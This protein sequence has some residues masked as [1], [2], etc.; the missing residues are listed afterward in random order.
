MIVDKN[1]LVP[2]SFALESMASFVAEIKSDRDVK[3]I[4]S[5]SKEEGL[6]LLALGDGTNIAPKPFLENIV[7]IFNTKGIE[8]VGAKL[9]I[10]AGVNW[11]EAVD[12]SVKVGL[13]GIE[14]LSGIPGKCGGAPIQNIGAYGREVS[15]A[16]ENVEIFDT[17]SEEFKIISKKDCEF[18]YRDSL[19]KR[20]KGRFLITHINLNLKKEKPKIPEYKDVKNY[21]EEKGNV[22]PSLTEIRNAILEIRQTKLPDPK[23]VPNCGSF[24]KNPFVSKT[25]AE[26][27]KATFPNMPTFESGNLIKIPA[28]FLIDSLGFKGQKIGKIE[29]YKNNA[30]VLTNPNQAKFDDLVYAKNKIQETVLKMFGIIL[31]PEV[32]IFE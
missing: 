29:V 23:K 18:G 9:R 25:E 15:D 16:L 13:S 22:S 7:A 5:F 1:A 4:F 6:P 3:E 20:E 26:K 24:F 14:P 8:R 17:K 28:G 32:N 2:N 19:F 30:L 27:L 21:F 11:D 10:A 31:E 12:F